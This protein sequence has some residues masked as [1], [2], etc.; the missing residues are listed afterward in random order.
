MTSHDTSTTKHSNQRAIVIVGPTAS[1]KSAYAVHA[2]H[3]LRACGITAEVI[4][5]DSRQVYTGLTIGTGKITP[6]EME[7]VPHHLLDVCNPNTIY[8]AYDFARDAHA[9]MRAVWQRGGIPILCGGTGLYLDA[10]FGR[11]PMASVPRNDALRRALEKHSAD[12]L[13]AQLLQA[14]PR[15]ARDI[16]A[17]NETHNI[18]RLVRALEIAQFHTTPRRETPAPTPTL[19][20]T[21]TLWLGLRPDDALLRTKIHTRLLHRLAHGMLEE[22]TRLHSEGLSWERMESLGL[23][24]RYCARHLQGSLSYD[25]L[26]TTLEAKIWQYARKQITYWRRNTEIAWYP[27]H[28]YP[29]LDARVCEIIQAP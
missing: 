1:G 11:I 4:S 26:T 17:K 21:P 3:M 19:A 24:Y 15:R 28:D 18:V 22:V 13:F 10:L 27:P 25:A 6:H 16:A 2:A 12:E 29:A 23:E 14:D 20:Y 7:G 5:A 8:T 9:V